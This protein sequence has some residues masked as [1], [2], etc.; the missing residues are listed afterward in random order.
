MSIESIQERARRRAQEFDSAV[1][2]GGAA[3]P[4][5]AVDL[6]VAGRRT[7]YDRA[8]AKARKADAD[9][10][11]T[12]LGTTSLNHRS[13]SSRGTGAAASLPA[14]QKAVGEAWNVRRTTRETD[15][16]KTKTPV[17]GK[18]IP[19]RDFQRSQ[20]E[21]TPPA[22]EK[23]KVPDGGKTVRKES[24][25]P[26]RKA[27][28]IVETSGQRTNRL[29]LEAQNK[30][31]AAVQMG[32]ES[33]AA[34]SLTQEADELAEEA[35]KKTNLRGAMENKSYH[36]RRLA[37]RDFYETM[38]RRE[39]F[40]PSVEAGE[41]ADF[42][43]ETLLPTAEGKAK[44]AA[45]A[46][47]NGDFSQSPGLAYLTPDERDTFFSY[48]GRQDYER[49]WDYLE[50]VS[51][52]ANA[53]EKGV[54]AGEEQALAQ[55][56]P[57]AAAVGNAVNSYLQPAAF[58]AN[59]GQAGKNLVTGEYEPTDPNSQW[60]SGAHGVQNTA[61][62]V[63]AAAV[64]WGEAHLGEGGGEAAGFLA[65]TGL[66]ILQNL[67]Q[68][69][70]GEPAALILMSASAAGGQTLSDLQAGATPG[71]AALSSTLVGA[72][73]YVTEKLPIDNIFRLA[74]TAPANL[75]QFVVELVKQMGSEALGEMSAEVIENAV[76]YCIY[77]GTGISD[78]EQLVGQLMAEGMSEEEAKKAAF[79]QI[80]VV[81]VGL[82][83]LGGAISGGVFGTG[84][85]AI[86][87]VGG[88][89]EQARSNETLRSAVEQLAQDGRVSN[90]VA[91]RVLTDTA[92]VETLT[93]EAGLA[94]EDTMSQ[95]QRRKAVKEAVETFA[96]PGTD[97][98]APAQ[99]EGT[100]STE[101][102]TAG[103]AAKSAVTRSQVLGGV[104]LG[105]SGK[106]AYQAALLPDGDV[107]RYTGGFFHY[108][109]AGMD[110]KPMGQV[111][112]EFSGDLTSAQKFAAWTA[113][114]NDA[115]VSLERGK[116]GAGLVTVY[117]QE[118]G[119]IQNEYSAQLP[120]RQAQELHELSRALGA[121]VVIDATAG[122]AQGRSDADGYLRDGVVHLAADAD[123]TVVIRHELT[124]RIQELAPEAYK[125]FRD[126]ALRFYGE[127]AVQEMFSRYYE[128]SD[129]RLQLSNEE[130]M[131]EIAAGFSGKLLTD[132]GSVKQLIHDDR[133]V[134]RKFFDTLKNLVQ[135]IKEKLGR[136]EPTLERAE[137]L[138]RDAFRE[139]QRQAAELNEQ[140]NAA[141]QET[142]GG[143]KYS[144]KFDEDGA[145]AVLEGKFDSDR[146]AVEAYLKGLVSDE[147]FSTVLSDAQAV[148][149]GKDLPGEY[150]RS[151]YTE[152]L[153][154]RLKKAKFKAA[155]VLGDMIL[156][157]DNPQFGADTG[158]KHGKRAQNGWY[159]YDTRFAVPVFNQNGSINHYT[160]YSAQLVVRNDADGKSYLY[161]IKE[162]RG[163]RQAIA[164]DGFTEP[165]MDTRASSAEDI[166]SQT[167]EEGNT[168]FSLKDTTPEAEAD[169][170][171]E[172]NEY[173]RAQM[174]RTPAPKTDTKAVQSAAK[175]V[176]SEYASGYDGGAL[177]GRL[178]A[179]YDHM[180]AGVDGHGAELTYESL[181]REAVDVAADVLREAVR[182]GNP[183]YDDYNSLR[184]YLREVKLNVPRSMWA[185]LDMAGGYQQF[186]KDNAGRLK[187]SVADGQAVDTVYKELSAK[188]PEFFDETRQANPADQLL[189]IADVLDGLEPV[190]ESAF[191]GP[192]AEGAVEYLAADLIE[193]FY[194]LPQ[195]APTFAD[196]QEQKLTAQKIHDNKK[197][198]R[199]RKEKN[200]RIEEIRRQGRERV[201]DAVSRER[202][203]GEERVT[204]IKEHYAEI[205]QGQRER[206]ADSKARS[207]LL[208]IA[209]RLQNK[210]MP[211]ANRALLNQ[212]IGELDT[213]AK[214]MTGQTIT[215][216]SDLKAWY[217]TQKRTDPD[218][219]S[220]PAT[221]AK[222][223]RLE[224]VSVDTLSPAQ[225]AELTE[226]LLNIENE[227]RTKDR[228]IDEEDRRDIYHMGE[229]V[230]SDVEAARGSK[231]GVMDKFIVTETL[232]PVRE[233]KR[234]TGYVE[235]DPLLRVTN[236]LA[237]GQRAMLDYQ[238]RAEKPFQSFAE[239]KPFRKTFSG[240]KAETI[241]IT[242]MAKG[243]PVTVEITPAMRTALYLHSLNDQNLRHIRDGG[244]TV[245][246]MALYRKGNLAEAYA[247]GTTVKL[248]PSQVRSITA[249]MTAQERAFARRAHDYYNGMSREAINQVSEK[250]KGYSLAQVE[251]Y[252]PI[253]TDT[254]FTK[255]DF[256]SIKF[257]GSIEGMGFLK[258]RVNAA[259]PILLRDVDAVV[260]Q[261]IR[262]HGK[263][264]G[265]AV[266]VRNFNKIWGV[267]TGSFNEDGSRNAFESS[268]QKAIKRKWG[269]TGFNYV[270]KM[271][272]DLQGG[273]APKNNW[274]K[275][276]GRVRSNYAG[277]V[278]TLN[279]SVAMKQ[280]AS[281]PTAAA[282]LGWTPLVRAMADNGPVD[283]DLI[284][285]YTPLQWYRSQ[286]FSTKELGDMKSQ[287]RQ[288][289]AVLNWVQGVDLLTT[290]KLWKASEYY[291]RYNDKTL[292]RG[293]DAY[294]R[295]LA[296]VYNRVIEETQPNYTTMQRPQLLRS[297]D[298]LMANL[299]MFKTQPFQNFNILY[300]A[301]AEYA[302]KRRSGSPAQ[303]KTARKNLGRAVT[304][305][306][307]QLAV[308]A[309]MTMAWALFRGKKDKYED[310]E[311]EMSVESLLKA[312][313]K[314]MVSGLF[315]E[316]PFGA[317]A[318]ELLSS[319]M[320]GDP[321]YGMDAVTVTALTD[322]LQS[323]SGLSELV[324]RLV[325]NAAAGEE[326][327][328]NAARLELDGYLDDI[329][330]AVGVPYENIMN[331]FN[332][333]YRQVS[334]KISG[335]YLG[336]YQAL[337][338]TEDPE[339]HS[340]DYYN[341]LYAAYRGDAGAYEEIYADMVQSGSFPEEKIKSAMEK[342]MKNDQ[343]VE[344]V[345]DLE[346]R[347]LSPEQK[348]QYDKVERAISGTQVYRRASEEQRE[349]AEDRLY[350]YVTGEKA[351]TE[352]L[353]E[354]DKAG[355]TP[356]EYLLYKLAC[357]VVSED[358]NDSTSQAEAEA[359]IKLLTGLTSRER[360]ALW[361]STNKGW[362]SESNPWG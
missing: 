152:T 52:E 166:I 137:K 13:G 361:Q 307:A 143:T 91:E 85:Q 184:S 47:R 358:G 165:T 175:A 238:M 225:V 347:Y 325:K 163:S 249:G 75:R 212:Y 298:S 162:I 317:D 92:A 315:A 167:G 141:G 250:L 94:L 219:I 283:L 102:G 16:G 231:G 32:G 209:K 117:N 24:E 53:R 217:E 51:W 36:A 357:E 33:A 159:Y 222:I 48:I 57:W 63:H 4:S 214:S 55:E 64:E 114:Q 161:D 72:T 337:K 104:A 112:S 316:V 229:A 157:A 28:R 290:R 359:A 216:L 7:L 153:F 15:T 41:R 190:Y 70:F 282:V 87:Y 82:A 279:L 39:N 254:S 220:D 327:G 142:D 275:A 204:R 2:G 9:M 122:T 237:D 187:L 106:K 29:K 234:L 12:A 124:H 257:D 242:G 108:Y 213:T 43:G 149:I 136:A 280:A 336:E 178:Q 335:K 35:G 328:W 330:K 265:M 342:R 353:E 155:G 196:R 314:D 193:R 274:A 245:P 362:K 191:T 248:T 306:L 182:Q 349:R 132:E 128:A 223:A 127:N 295:A 256:E 156:I 293:T 68:M 140:N 252:F 103:L 69:P 260:E 272:A 263:Y 310:E 207:R 228:L 121:K 20:R 344:S 324:G 145:I 186:K 146:K 261:S 107:T 333:V 205:R 31:E 246:D 224:K 338:L 331:L 34:R 232:S 45:L 129:G 17:L 176:L 348:E 23:V 351:L 67:A 241:Q 192:E 264:V 240:A 285:K 49:A 259:N 206:R 60:F 22:A 291:V 89:M 40:Q 350:G 96:R 86:G 226:I 255:S 90:T 268:V 105:E 138:W 174:K 343:G 323:F 77:D 239:D 10:G 322:T 133:T 329:S 215:K 130:V 321:Y 26:E 154:S 356:E 189:Q 339:K 14:P 3:V 37:D 286:G 278:L 19:A 334:V 99:G 171:R 302:A 304:S 135:T 227:M 210:K 180:A 50:I 292:N 270:E 118:A 113:G 65:D 195:Q 98:T 147:V 236:A 326:I 300:D 346:S 78:F 200:A 243:G 80:G 21:D 74:R 296:E 168:K 312:M 352:K 164:A 311:G 301:A 126:Y 11:A 308:F 194:E 115:K 345:Q 277:A 332:A 244:I 84:A 303:V 95:S 208:E 273:T 1:K 221:E 297:D 305:Q 79:Y 287:N 188:W 66:S 97:T 276:L 185:D 203:R 120:A 202:S 59:L 199:L 262:Q 125:S 46:L 5:G 319:Q 62:G 151:E 6:S 160:P 320:F 88:R 148:Y 172:L 181:R 100:A 123:V 81:N 177:S 139:A 230:I 198:E 54:R 38:A 119:L 197:L 271:M 235:A 61:A 281:Y 83:G 354:L 269:E 289:P 288:L 170:L 218:F 173:L 284:A 267:T 340:A 116:G 76:N 27:A 18:T 211:E 134:A 299:A 109:N 294:Y 73:E 101:K 341:V 56:H 8:L 233:M 111:R 44:R 179:M 71:Q 183:L 313:G 144:I 169:R 258:E 158:G 318:W 110:G 30:R 309:G 247:R 58:A 355:I 93:R 42:T 253:Q 251:N 25:K 360:A 266:P 201:Q 131:D 150:T